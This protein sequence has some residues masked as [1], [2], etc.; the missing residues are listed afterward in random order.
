MAPTEFPALGCQHKLTRYAGGGISS[1]YESVPPADIVTV[2]TEDAV[3]N[4]GGP[5][6]VL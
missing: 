6:P 2:P 1:G 5:P 3:P 4:P